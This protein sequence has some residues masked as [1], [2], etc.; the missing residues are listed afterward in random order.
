[1]DECAV[2]DPCFLALG[3]FDLWPLSVGSAHP[4]LKAYRLAPLPSLGASAQVTTDLPIVYISPTTA[5]QL[6]RE[7]LQH[8]TTHWIQERV[9]LGVQSPELYKIDPPNSSTP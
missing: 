7:P 2:R 9:F 6:Q 5:Y 4:N 3:H 8:S 1:M